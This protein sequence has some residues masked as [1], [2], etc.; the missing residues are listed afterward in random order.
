MNIVFLRRLKGYF[1]LFAITTAVVGIIWFSA[2]VSAIA[3]IVAITT[4]DGGSSVDA[5]AN[6]IFSFDQAIFAD[7]STTAFT[8]PA[9]TASGLFSVARESDDS[10][11]EGVWTINN[12]ATIV[13]FTPNTDFSE[14]DTAIMVEV[15]GDYYNAE[16]EQGS[17]ARESFTV[18][19]T[20]PTIVSA[21]YS[22][23]RIT[24]TASEPVYGLISKEAF[25][26]EIADGETI[27]PG[28]VAGLSFTV[29][30]A[31]TLIALNL[32]STNTI[33]PGSVVTFSY[34]PTEGSE[35]ISDTATNQLAGF[36]TMSVTEEQPQESEPTVDDTTPPVITL[37]GD[38]PMTIPVG[39]AYIDP[40]TTVDGE[41]S[42]SSNANTAVDTS[43]AS[44]YTV[45]YTAT[46]TAG[47]TGTTTRTVIVA[48]EAPL[49]NTPDTTPPVITLIGD[50]PMTIPVGDAYIDPGTTVDGEE[51]VSSNANTAVDTSVASTYTVTYTAT[52]T[53]GNTGTTTRTV[54]VAAEAPPENTPDTPPTDQTPAD[55]TTPPTGTVPSDTQTTP[56]ANEQPVP[57]SVTIDPVADNASRYINGIVV[58]AGGIIISGTA[59][60]IAVDAIIILNLTD[61]D[62][63]TVVIGAIEPDESTGVWT[64]LITAAHIERF[65]EGDITAYASITSAGVTARS[66]SITFVY[67]MTAPT[68][69]QVIP[70]PTPTEDTTPDFVFSSDEAGTI[71]Y[72]GDCISTTNTDATEGNNTVTFDTLIAGEYGNCTIV[73]TDT[74]GNISAT[75]IVN[76]FTVVTG[77]FVTFSIENGVRLA[78][79]VAG[80]TVSFSEPVYSDNTASTQFTDTTIADIITLRENDAAGAVIPFSTTIS[81]QIV[82]IVPTNPLTDGVVY[83]AVTDGY[84]NA[85]GEQGN[86]K[87]MSF[88]VDTIAPTIAS[89]MYSGTAVTVTMNEPIYGTVPAD[90]FTLTIVKDLVVSLVNP[91]SISGLALAASD[92]TDTFTLE[93]TQDRTIES[94]ST[95][96]LSYRPTEDTT[97]HINDIATNTFAA[98]TS[99][100]VSEKDTTPPNMPTVSPSSETVVGVSTD[101]TVAFDEKV[102]KMDGTTELELADFSG[103]ESVFIF[104]RLT[105]NGGTDTRIDSYT[106]TKDGNTFTVNPANNLEEGDEYRITI[107]DDYYDSSGNQ[108]GVVRVIFAIEKEKDISKDDDKDDRDNNDKDK[109]DKD[110][111]D[112][113]DKEPEDDFVV[114]FFPADDMRV[115]DP[116]TDITITFSQPIYRT[117]KNVEFTESDLATFVMLRTGDEF[118]YGISFN[119]S[120]NEEKT[121]ITVDSFEEDLV[122][123]VYVAISAD[124]YAA[125][126]TRGEAKEA[127]FSVINDEVEAL[128]T[129]FFSRIFLDLFSGTVAD[130]PTILQTYSF[131]MF[132]VNIK[133]AQTL[134]NKSG[135]PVSIIGSEGPEVMTG[136]L[137]MLTEQALQCYQEARGLPLSGELTPQTFDLLVSEYY[138]NELGIPN[139]GQLLVV[140]E[141][142]FREKILM[143]TLFMVQRVI[144]MLSADI[145]GQQPEQPAAQ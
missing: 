36:T 27:T 79:T 8:A 44:T 138:Q 74:A 55:D 104:E 78:E 35:H 53:A 129:N 26:I 127:V 72:G 9:L 6:I 17:M 124:Y 1:V 101:I 128:F 130:K 52:D 116:I 76:I 134:L 142:L 80:L 73:V 133:L 50:N 123:N 63:K 81:G 7:A 145:F 114:T 5:N 77:P 54:I 66:E 108:G 47:N 99:I 125:D 84:Y 110:N 22:S 100:S 48:A 49:E 21:T 82:V 137:D 4:S 18:D 65:T 37:I 71:T 122:G 85:T 46:D 141:D 113:E 131:G 88:A 136:Y 34:A 38:N 19:T 56:F 14:D 15:T 92:A 103:T 143:Q 109:D 118:G 135:C 70:V 86:A 112:K 16:G 3:P 67:D 12:N 98:V 106:V 64:A 10:T 25:A 40:G 28:N 97:E 24:L 89:A 62:E 119:A 96:H 39:D 31:N 115:T 107:T 29:D 91:V 144:M 32:S 20:P 42:V 61:S 117:M 75:L 30:N 87:N 2:T 13:T 140:N 58:A 57:L 41:E 60:G 83:L 43:V 11:I 102:Y 69:S 94:G 68:L 59:T 105:S 120:I 139:F 23:E 33:A 121:V 132:D 93:L 111:N 95:A 90:A 126:G 45:T 51:S